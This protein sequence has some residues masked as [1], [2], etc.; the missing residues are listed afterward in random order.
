MVIQNP[1]RIILELTNK[2]NLRCIMC[3][4]NHVA[5][6]KTFLNMG[7][8]KKLSNFFESADEVTLFG[9]GEPLLNKEF[10]EILEFVSQYKNLKTYL[11]TNG[12]VL[13]KYAEMIVKK[14]LTYLSIS[15]DGGTEDTYKKI[16]RG[17]NINNILNALQLIK[18]LKVQ[19]D[20]KS[21]YLRFIFVAMKDN[22]GELPQLLDLAHEHGVNEIKVEY[23]VAHTPE[24]VQQS[25]FYHREL[26]SYFKEAEQ[27]AKVSNVT[28]TLPPLIGKDTVGDKLHRD[29]NAPFDTFFLSSNG[30]V[31][32]CMISNEI[33]GNIN[34]DMAEDIWHGDKMADFR[35]RILSSNQPKDCRTCWQASH[36]NVNREEAHVKLYVDIAGQGVSEK[37]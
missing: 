16:R 27:K 18:D 26:L 5:F 12:T 30:D 9:Y 22:I 31:R 13:S 24:L 21:P 28:L 2:C 25:L 1:K 33:F 19:Y 17:G 36:L 6:D 11:L 10:P 32:A 23:L 35:D 15:I 14:Q 3:A 37:P 34:N 8:V 7:M 29:C 20:T 4:Q